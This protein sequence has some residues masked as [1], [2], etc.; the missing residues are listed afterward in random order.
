[1]LFVVSIGYLDAQS[2]T[3]PSTRLGALN[4]EVFANVVKDPDPTYFKAWEMLQLAREEGMPTLESRAHGY[5]STIWNQR[6]RLDSTI[7]HSRKSL[8]LSIR[9][10]SAAEISNGYSTLGNA[11]ETFGELDSAYA[12]FENSYQWGLKSNNRRSISRGLLNMG[13]VQR[14]LGDYLKSLRHLHEAERLCLEWKAYPFLPNLY[15]TMGEVYLLLGEADLAS[16]N[17]HK[18]LAKSRRSKKRLVAA[19]TQLSLG[20]HAMLIRDT[21]EALCWFNASQQTAR[22]GHYPR[23]EAL[24]AAKI[25]ETYLALGRTVDA[26]AAAQVAVVIGRRDDDK[27]ILGQAFLAL[28]LVELQLGN[29]EVAYRDCDQAHAFARQTGQTNERIAICECLWK[30]AEKAGKMS[31]AFFQHREFIHLRDSLHNREGN[32]EIARFEANLQYERQRVTDRISQANQRLQ[33]EVAYQMQL[34]IEKERTRSWWWISGF[35]AILA[36][37]GGLAVIIIRR[38][39]RRLV[40]QNGLIQDQNRSI[41]NTLEEKEVLLR[42]VHHRVKNNLQVMVSLLEMQASKVEDLNAIEALLTSKGRVQAMSLIHKK[43]YQQSNITDV[44]FGEYLTQLVVAIEG[45]HGVGTKVETT[46]DLVECRFGIDTAVPLGLILNELIT[47]A[48][49]YAF[50]G[51]AEGRLSLSL[52][53]NSE[54]TYD[55]E[56]QDDGNGLPQ[57]FDLD[58]SDTMGLQLVEGLARQLR[59]RF[60]IGRSLWGGPLFTVRFTPQSR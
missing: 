23:L 20:T 2:D 13:M 45:L 24:A 55:L 3:C 29:F 1:M 32:M 46:F 48:Y 21:S 8:E 35:A 26:M 19:R 25:S 12:A 40:T 60:M 18:A 38:Q 37:G 5:L 10:G 52:L 53:Q 59:G 36:V 57:G 4:K 22:E 15:W 54:G 6:N 44:N 58:Q 34:G 49:K 9:S 11:L 47:N 27:V 30:S 31:V 50:V 39:N 28:G 41:Q 43:L 17:L 7:F 33:R 16:E 42:E 56:V 51:R 14:T